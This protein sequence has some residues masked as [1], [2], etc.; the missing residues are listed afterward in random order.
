MPNH[1]TLSGEVISNRYLDGA[2]RLTPSQ[3]KTLFDLG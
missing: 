1:Q 3:E 2:D